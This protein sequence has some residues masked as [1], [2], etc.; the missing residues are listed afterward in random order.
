MSIYSV[1]MVVVADDFGMNAHRTDAI[2]AAAAFGALTRTSLL[3]NGED[4]ARAGVT[5]RAAMLEMGLHFNITEA[6][7]VSHP[8]P[9]ETRSCS[10]ITRPDGHPQAGGFLGKR[11]LFRTLER[12]NDR[13]NPLLRESVVNTIAQELRAQLDRFVE[14]TN[15]AE[16]WLDGHHHVHVLELV[17][18]AIEMVAGWSENSCSAPKP[19]KN[20]RWRIVGIRIPYDPSLIVQLAQSESNSKDLIG[21]PDGLRFHDDESIFGLPFWTRISHLAARRRQR[22]PPHICCPDLFVGFDIG[23]ADASVD[24]LV[25]KV[26]DAISRGG[27]SGQPFVPPRW[28]PQRMEQIL[29][30][31]RK[32]K[33]GGN[34]AVSEVVVELMTHPGYADGYQPLADIGDTSGDELFLDDAKSMRFLE[35]SLYTDASFPAT[36]L[37]RLDATLV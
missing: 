35:W 16:V 4:G 24:A 10:L 29:S 26:Q 3:V 31:R 21:D 12:C 25:W 23:G 17:W 8:A 20:D 5:G 14:L 34:E 13:S 37:S 22:V 32:C 1:R 36:M 15:V 30:R 2:L 18:E 33:E 7:P 27:E 28:R 11:D 6:F 19:S 9:S